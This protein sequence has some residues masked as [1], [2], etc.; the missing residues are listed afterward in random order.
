MNQAFTNKATLALQTAQALAQEAGHPELTSAHL[1]VAL[2]DEPEG[3]M[4]AVLDRLEADPAVLRAELERLLSSLPKTSGTEPSPSRDLSGVLSQATAQAKKLGDAF[5]STEHLLL[6]LAKSGGAGVSELFA[7]RQL[8]PD[9]IETALLETRGSRRVDTADPE[10]TFEA[11]ERYARDLTADARAG[12]LDP[13]I[14]RAEE[15]RRVMQV[16]SRRRKN[17][18]VL[19]GDPGVGK[20]AIAEGLANRIVAGDVPEGLKDKRIM[21]LD[22]GSLLAGAKYRGEFEERL[23][24]ILTGDRR[25][26]G[27]RRSSSSTSC[28]RSSAPAAPRAR[29]TRPTC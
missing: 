17:N 13:V 10:S 23:K 27:R 24:A 20:T 11:L 26:R 22:M 14:G 6:A 12:K 29:S 15:I 5:V 16:L 4:A 7:S 28:T 18:P 2:L 19:I 25:G 9:R 3:L 8:G 21:A 1:A